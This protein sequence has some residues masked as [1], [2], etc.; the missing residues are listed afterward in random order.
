MFEDEAVAMK[1]KVYFSLAKTLDKLFMRLWSLL[2]GAFML[3]K[4]MNSCNYGECSCCNKL[5]DSQPTEKELSYI[6]TLESRGFKNVKLTIP[7]IGLKGYGMSTYYR[8]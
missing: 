1:K 8:T 5:E 4:V 3:T 2:L 7:A 6:D